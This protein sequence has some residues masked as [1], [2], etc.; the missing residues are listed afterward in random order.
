MYWEITAIREVQDPAPAK[1]AG[2]FVLQR[3]HDGDGPHFDLRLEQGDH[4]TGWRIAGETLEAGCWA[5]EKM[6]HPLKWLSEDG[7]TRRENEGV[8]AWQ[9]RS[10]RDCSL[11]LMSPSGTVELSLKR[12]SS[13]GVEE[14]RALAS[15]LQE[16]GKERASLS[17]LVEDGLRARSRSILRFCGLSRTLDG[18]D[19]D[20]TGRRRLLEGMTL[21]EIDER[22][23]KVETRYD[24]QLPPEPVSRPEPLDVDGEEERRS[25]IR[26]IVGEK[27]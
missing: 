19:F 5:T 11:L 3:H 9:Q 26:R 12:C 4:L 6:P 25:R 14:M 13:P 16:H 2:R 18:D 1:E 10:D 17:A 21:S 24:R 7:D 20:E 27:H 23:A 22:L 8:Y 15:T